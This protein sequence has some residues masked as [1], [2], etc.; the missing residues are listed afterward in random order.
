MKMIIDRFEGSFAVIELENGVFENMP[1]TLLPKNS[2]EGDIIII[3]ISDNET[4]A[5]KE[6]IKNKIDRLFAD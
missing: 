2:K 5:R 3:S 1:K 6:N 4:L